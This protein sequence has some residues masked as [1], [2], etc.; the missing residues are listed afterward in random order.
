M[1]RSFLHSFVDVD[2]RLPISQL[3]PR[4]L[5]ILACLLSSFIL[6]GGLSGLSQIDFPIIQFLR[7]TPNQFLQEIGRIGNQLGHGSTLIFLSATALLVGYLWKQRQLKEI[8]GQT[9][10]AHGVAGLITQIIK[11]SLG[12]PRPRLAHQEHWQMGPSFQSGLDAFPSGHSSA[13]FAVAAVLVRHFPRYAWVIYGSATFVAFSRII[14]GSHF[15]SDACVGALLGYVIGYILSRPIRGWRQ[16]FVEALSKGL[17]CFVVAFSVLW[18]TVQ[19][20]DI[21][22]LYYVILLSGFLV[23][24]VGYGVRTRALFANQ[25]DQIRKP[26]RLA[27]SSLLMALGLALCTG[28]FLVTVLAALAGAVWWMVRSHQILTSNETRDYL[29][30]R[31]L[32]TTTANEIMIGIVVVFLMGFIYQLRGL[33]PLI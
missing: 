29:E 9:L 18:I 33:I 26:T 16:S 21:E 4:W 31:N 25:S 17:P 32:F 5:S 3:F 7:A 13:S 1:I 30:S 14:K 24:L 28:S 6:L 10:L 19:K 23:A 2:S 27:T 11:H 15:P 8:G 12:R 22:T 20:P